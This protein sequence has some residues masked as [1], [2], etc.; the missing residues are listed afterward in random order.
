[1]KK[2]DLQT[3]NQTHLLSQNN[4]SYSNK[5]MAKKGLEKIEVKIYLTFL[6][7]S[8]RFNPSRKDG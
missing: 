4:A 2:D 3:I 8:M 7:K 1:M 5:T 6:S